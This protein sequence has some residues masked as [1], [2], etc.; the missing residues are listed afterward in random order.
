MYNINETIVAIATPPGEGA[1]GIIR[2]SGDK[3]FAITKDIFAGKD[4][5]KQASHTIHFGKIMD[6]DEIIDEVVVSLYKGPKSYTGEDVVEISCHGSQYVLERVLDLCLRNGAHLAKAGEFTQRAFLNNKMDL[7]QAEAVADLIASQSSAAHKAAIHNLRGGFSS[8]L[9]DLREQLIQF[10]ALLELE[11]DFS[12][13]DVEFADRTRF[14]DLIAALDDTTHRLIQ[15]FSLGNVIKK[16]VSVA[17]IGKPNAGKSTLLNALLNEERAIVSDIAGT[18]RD[19]IEEVLNINGILFRLID[20]AG[21]REH[22]SDIVETM[23]VQRSRDIMKRAD[24]VVYLFDVNEEQPEELQQQVTVFEQEGMKYLLVGNKSDLAGK[25]KFG[26]DVLYIS[27]KQKENIQSLRQSLYDHVID[28]RVYT[29]GTI[30]TNARHHTALQEVLKSL[31]DIKAGLDNHIS[32]DLVALDVRRC[33]H[34]LG[35]ITGQVTTEDKLDYIF[36]K[37]CI[38]K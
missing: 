5:T 28:G 25:Q 1:I 7:A 12:E 3:A 30:V 17:I 29:E 35:E 23:G 27:A 21:I 26:N 9:Q 22:T 37:F 20:T 11:L 31:H 33:L 8:E 13:E 34:Y 32:G 36:S 15:S 4:L 14:Y 19:S 24:V 2:L 38:G 6:G 10:S 16:G 18:T